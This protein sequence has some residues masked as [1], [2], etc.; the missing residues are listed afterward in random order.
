MRVVCSHEIGF[1]GAPVFRNIPSDFWVRILKYWNQDRDVPFPQKIQSVRHYFV[2]VFFLRESG[3]NDG[4]PVVA[5][6]HW[7]EHG[8]KTGATRGEENHSEPHNF[9]LEE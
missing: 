4:Y 3:R 6:R 2:P 5:G 9:H 1:W 8:G 7:Q